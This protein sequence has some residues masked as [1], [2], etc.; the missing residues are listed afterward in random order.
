MA[1]ASPAMT[2]G[3]RSAAA[4]ASRGSRR[5][6]ERAA[7]LRVEK[8]AQFARVARVFELAQRLGLDL[9]D[10][11]AGHRELLPDLFEGVIGV[12]ADAEAHAQ[13]ALLARRQRRQDP[14]RRLAQIGLD[15]GVEWQ[16]GILVL[17]EITEMGIL[18]VAD[19]GFEADR[20][21][22]D[23]QDLAHLFRAASPAC[24]PAPRG[25]ARGRSRAASGA[26]CAPAC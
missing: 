3:E 16:D 22:G 23:L 12:H 7:R 4:E 2:H 19:R 24:R 5:D 26:R 8:A 1:R 25:S 21:L 14:R 15:G 17:D 11:L 18:L 9:A 20:L 13:D 6:L 10:A